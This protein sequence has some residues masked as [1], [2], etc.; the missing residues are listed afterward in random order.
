[1]NPA[2]ASTRHSGNAWSASGTGNASQRGAEKPLL[3]S[4]HKV[5]WYV[6]RV[7]PLLTLLSLFFRGLDAFA[8][9]E[10]LWP[11]RRPGVGIVIGMRTYHSFNPDAMDGGELLDAIR[12]L[13]RLGAEFGVSSTVDNWGGDITRADVADIDMTLTDGRYLYKKGPC[14]LLF[15][16]VQVTADGRV[17]AC[18]CRD[19]HGLLTLGDIGA[20]PLADILSVDNEKWTRI[21]ADQA[22]GRFNSVCASCGLYR[23]IHDERRTRDPDGADLMTKEEYFALHVPD[24]RPATIREP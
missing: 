4:R 7:K 11:A 21:V 12:R 16:S 23:S 5:L 17:N 6:G 8:A 3:K 14:S 24:S 19:P 20:T 9:L 13:R 2:T 10:R 1:M 15:D 18:A 22:A